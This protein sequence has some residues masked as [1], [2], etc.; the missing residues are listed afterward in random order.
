MGKL[1]VILVNEARERERDKPNGDSKN[2]GGN[3]P[4]LSIC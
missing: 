1:N 3:W 4:N 2:Y